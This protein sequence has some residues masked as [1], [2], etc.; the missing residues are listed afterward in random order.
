MLLFL[1]QGGSVFSPSLVQTP[2]TARRQAVDL[3]KDLGC[4]TSDLTDDDKLAA[5]LRATPVHTLNAAQTK[6]RFKKQFT[7]MV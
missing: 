5:C 6:V 4:V 3:A 7:T 1:L 2:S